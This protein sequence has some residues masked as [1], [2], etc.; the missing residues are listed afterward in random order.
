MGRIRRTASSLR[1]WSAH[2]G[3][4]NEKRTELSRTARGAVARAALAPW[5]LAAPATNPPAGIIAFKED[6]P[7]AVCLADLGPR[8]LVL[9][10]RP[11]E[12]WA[13]EALATVGAAARR[14]HSD[15]YYGDEESDP[16][17]GLRL[18]PDWSPILARSADL[19]GRAWITRADW[20]RRLIGARRAIEIADR[21]LPVDEGL[22]ATHLR[23]VLARCAAPTALAPRDS[24]RPPASPVQ[25][26]P[27]ATIVIP[28]RDRVDL[29]RG[30][31][32]SL[33]RVKGR[34]DFEVIVVDN[35][36]EET[37][38]LAY[39]NDI[40]RD[41]RFRVL[42]RPGP[43]NF[44]ALCNTGVDGARAVTLVFLNNDTKALSPHWLDRLI[45]WTRLPSVGAVG[46]KLIYPNGQL[47][48]VGVVIGV[49]GHA[50]H[51]ERFRPR[52]AGG[53]FGRGN[54]PHEVSAVTGA[55]LAVEKAKFDAIGGFD[56]VNLPIE[57]SDIDL[58]LRLAERGWTALLEPAAVLV[59][60]E[61]A[62]RKL[63]RSQEKRYAGQ[64]AY[65]KARWRRFLRDDP[66]FHPAL[67]LDWHTA[68]LG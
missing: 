65:F 66:Y 51:F 36:S 16:E 25:D 42:E 58:C 19:I 49:D 56:A 38:T 18:K 45:A 59:H 67:S 12:D 41:S 39:L 1:H 17:R 53:Y 15:V 24:P 9:A 63:W 61:A 43:F 3:D 40:P 26:R 29:L 55:C 20:A 4:C 8:D 11:G 54:L 50:T 7:L 62:T 10:V 27:C 48:H 60:H 52:N 32:E 37:A 23:R 13:P 44:S 33:Q 21:P 28:T 5:S 22:R 57:F 6:A 14:D 30:C 68:A 31:V 64:V 2:S 46:A 47:R 34:D 35:S